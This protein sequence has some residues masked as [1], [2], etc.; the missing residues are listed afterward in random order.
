[1]V[2]SPSLP[3]QILVTM[4]LQSLPRIY[5]KKKNKYVVTMHLRLPPLAQLTTASQAH[6]MCCTAAVM[7]QEDTVESRGS[8]PLS[9]HTTLVSCSSLLTHG[10]P[11]KRNPCH[12]LSW[13]SYEKHFEQISN[14]KGVLW[15]AFAPL[16][17]ILLHPKA[18]FVSPFST[19]GWTQHSYAA[20]LTNALGLSGHRQ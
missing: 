14:V 3:L 20:Y 19:P 1:M 18:N 10:L 13:I 12:A 4:F 2:R 6:K 17:A 11:R 16:L 5:K 15:E 7:P 8:S 9:D